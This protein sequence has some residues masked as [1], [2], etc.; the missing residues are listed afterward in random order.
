MTANA[1]FG[2]HIQ[3]GGCGKAKSVMIRPD[4]SR[5]VIDWDLNGHNI[6]AVHRVRATL[7]RYPIMHYVHAD[8]GPEVMA[9]RSDSI[10]KLGWR[11]RSFDLPLPPETVGHFNLLREAVSV[12]YAELQGHPTKVEFNYPATIF[13]ESWFGWMDRFVIHLNLPA[14]EFYHML[15]A[16]AG[17]AGHPSSHLTLEPADIKTCP[18]LLKWLRPFEAAKKR[19]YRDNGFDWNPR[20]GPIELGP[21]KG[22]L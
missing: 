11:S 16:V 14:C 12:A 4:G 21:T 1:T 9:A 2:G 8:Y 20:R 3:C 10:A 19:L 7:V 15:L 17:A 22:D 6:P 18:K 13:V 5:D